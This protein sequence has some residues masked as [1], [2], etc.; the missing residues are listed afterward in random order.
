MFFSVCHSNQQEEEDNTGGGAEKSKKKPF[1][2]QKNKKTATSQSIDERQQQETQRVE[3]NLQG[4]PR[5]TFKSCQRKFRRWRGRK[6]Q[7]KGSD[8]G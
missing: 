4:V 3:A 7:E 8:R 5:T 2:K 1:P 6:M